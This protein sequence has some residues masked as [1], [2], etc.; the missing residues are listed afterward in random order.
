MCFLKAVF[1]S[2]RPPHPQPPFNAE[3]TKWIN[4]STNIYIIWLFWV[5]EQWTS[6]WLWLLFLTQLQIQLPIFFY[7]K[8]E[9]RENITFKDVQNID[10]KV[11]V[12]ILF[13]LGS[14][15]KIIL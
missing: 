1:I 11:K 8:S 10:N 4:E 9:K 15:N 13:Q 5:I 14:Q 7:S 2:I 6:I 12:S 3:S